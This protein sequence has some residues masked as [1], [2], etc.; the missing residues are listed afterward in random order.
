LFSLSRATAGASSSQLGPAA[1]QHQVLDRHRHAIQQTLR[2]TL[3]PARLGRARGG[4]RARFVDQAQRIELRVGGGDALEREL[5]R[6]DGRDG[7]A[8]IAVEQDGG[9]PQCR[10]V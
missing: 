10:I 8:A 5:R 4:K 9:R 2:S 7:A 6:L 1:G 3:R